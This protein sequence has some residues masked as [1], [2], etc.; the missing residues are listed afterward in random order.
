VK[1]SQQVRIS[2]IH[3]KKPGGNG[4]GI[5]KVL[6]NWKKK[7]GVRNSRKTARGPGLYRYR[8]GGTAG[9]TTLKKGNPERPKS[10]EQEEKD[11]WI[12]DRY[13]DPKKKLSADGRKGWRSHSNKPT[14]KEERAKEHALRSVISR[15]GTS[16]GRKIHL[17]GIWGQVKKKT[18]GSGEGLCVLLP[19]P[20]IELN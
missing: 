3:S 15:T 18:E 1:N 20:E 5:G 11:Y 6:E 7:K 14:Q 12:W 19:F 8:R 16:Q 10:P 4:S 13:L 9:S 17:R 2:S